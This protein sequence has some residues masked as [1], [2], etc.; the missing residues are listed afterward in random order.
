MGDSFKKVQ[1]G[2][3]LE[4]SASVWNALL[5]VARQAKESQHDQTQQA[6]TNSRQTSYALV[7]NQS[8][9]DLD[10]FAV[11]ELGSP[12]I[13]PVDNQ[14]E[15]KNR[16]SFQASLPSDS[17]GSRIGVTIEPIASGA[18][19][20]AAVAGIVPVRLGATSVL[21][22]CVQPIAGATTL[23][24]VPHGPASLLWAESTFGNCWAIMRID[25][26]NLEEIVLVTSNIPDEQG[27]Y[28]G[29]VQRY[30]IAGGAWVSQF[31]CKVLDAN[32]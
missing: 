17:T 19:G 31:P 2:Q 7:R 18:I 12:I 21:Y 1:A 23:Q 25:Q 26:S 24:S 28:P 8:G 20:T 16:P 13:S 15:F 3:P 11:I 32:R 4:V 30:D 9:V 6:R 29:I 10:R 22:A 5:D 14:L 27:F